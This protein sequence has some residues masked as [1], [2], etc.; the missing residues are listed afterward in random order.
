M[1]LR[2]N[3]SNCTMNGSCE[4]LELA[5]S[6]MLQHKI[7]AEVSLLFLFIVVVFVFGVLGFF[8][9]TVWILLE[10]FNPMSFSE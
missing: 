6:F 2:W 9:A 10:L 3:L 7:D 8:L 4:N 1:F 5:H